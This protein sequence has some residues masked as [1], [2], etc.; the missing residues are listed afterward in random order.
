MEE[1]KPNVDKTD[2]GMGT[3]EVDFSQFHRDV[4]AQYCI[5]HQW[6]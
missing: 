5:L 2:K 3:G 1:V 4:S 6:L